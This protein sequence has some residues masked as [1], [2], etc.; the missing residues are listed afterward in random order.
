MATQSESN[1]YWDQLPM[2]IWR[3]I[4]SYASAQDLVKNIAKVNKT[5]YDISNSLIDMI[6]LK[7][8]EIKLSKVGRNEEHLVNGKIVESV[9]MAKPP[10][11]GLFGRFHSIKYLSLVMNRPRY[12]WLFQVSP[13]DL[14]IFDILGQALEFCK[15]ITHLTISGEEF[16][17]TQTYKTQNLTHVSLTL[18]STSKRKVNKL[19]MNCEKLSALKIEDTST[20]NDIPKTLIATLEKNAKTLTQL[21]LPTIYYTPRVLKILPRCEKLSYIEAHGTDCEYEAREIENW[22][23]KVSA[24]PKLKSLRLCDIHLSEPF[25]FENPE[26]FENLAKTMEEIDIWE[27]EGL[28]NVLKLFL[29]FSK[30]KSLSVKLMHSDEL[31]RDVEGCKNLKTLHLENGLTPAFGHFLSKIETFKDLTLAFYTHEDFEHLALILRTGSFNKVSVL[32]VYACISGDVDKQ[33][34]DLL[35]IIADNFK[36][37]KKLVLTSNIRRENHN[38][39]DV[40]SYIINEASLRKVVDNCQNLKDF[41]IRI[42][43][44]SISEATKEKLKQFKNVKFAK[45]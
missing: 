1:I 30:L 4:L 14:P 13:S 28:G 16:K 36:N 6:Q 20:T 8:D 15:N 2:E 12:S 37:L 9:K 22:F 42:L 45:K 34:N 33:I 35:E 31:P 18:S 27:C 7:F 5:F 25:S 19:L 38:F 21:N 29:N 17:A 24:L 11:N 26:K 32:T 10:G 43:D 23:E 40:H 41:E 39:P 44:K 3:E